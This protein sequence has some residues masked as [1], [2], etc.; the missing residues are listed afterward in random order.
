MRYFVRLSF[1]GTAYHG[2]QS[3]PN[4]ITVQQVMEETLSTI[5]RSPIALTGAGRTDTG[6]HAR[7]MVAH[8]DWHESFDPEQRER[9]VLRLNSLLPKDIA[10]QQ[11]VPVSD[12]AHARFSALSRTYEYWV[13]TEKDPFL[14]LRAARVPA[15]MD[16]EAMN[17]AAQLLLKTTDFGSF[18]KLHTD[19]KTT[20]C[21]LTEAQWL[22]SQTH[23]HVFRITANRFLR[24]MVRAIVGTLFDVGMHKMSNL[25]LEHIIAQRHR[26]A[27]G[28]SAPAHGL[29]LTRITYPEDIMPTISNNET[30]N[31]N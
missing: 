15:D 16:F 11:I 22:P 31:N 18:C 4:G 20:L 28:Q 2:W 3:Q 7:M 30:P 6:V 26:T 14:E 12:D 25:Q 1:L 5:F 24:N 13:T 17:E 10:V 21:E 27:A 23:L 29:Y 19:V 9:L 8:F